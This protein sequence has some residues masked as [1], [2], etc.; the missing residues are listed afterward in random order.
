MASIFDLTTALAASTDGCVMTWLRLRV[1]GFRG[2]FVAARN[3]GRAR[4]LK[5]ILL[6]RVDVGVEN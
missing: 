5:F 3:L 1:P 2:P 4:S 6:Q